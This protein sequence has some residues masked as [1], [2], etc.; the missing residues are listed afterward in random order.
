MS[1][2]EMG[3]NDYPSMIDYVLEQTGLSKLAFIAHSQGSTAMFYALTTDKL[4]YF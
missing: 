3:Y 1:F 2:E 4:A